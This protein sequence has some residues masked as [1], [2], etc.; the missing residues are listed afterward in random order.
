M[1]KELGGKNPKV[2]VFIPFIHPPALRRVFQQSC[3]LGN[4]EGLLCQWVCC[5]TACQHSGKGLEGST[6]S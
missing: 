6:H 4:C 3:F 2:T 1:S 5:Q